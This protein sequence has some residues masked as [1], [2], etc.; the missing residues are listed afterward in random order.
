MKKIDI[1]FSLLL[2]FWMIAWYFSTIHYEELES[3]GIYFRLVIALLF[4]IVAI[5]WILGIREL[6]KMEVKDYGN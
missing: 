4:F 5:I 6:K 2:I 1:Y 3:T